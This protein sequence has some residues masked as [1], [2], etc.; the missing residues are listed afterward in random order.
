M[1]SH[2]LQNLGKLPEVLQPCVITIRAAEAEGA[3]NKGDARLLAGLQVALGVADVDGIGQTEVQE[4]KVRL[5]FR[6]VITE[7]AMPF[8]C[9]W[10]N[11]L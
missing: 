2:I 9:A 10:S 1:I 3:E 11:T 7:N 4:G 5:V 6:N 8:A